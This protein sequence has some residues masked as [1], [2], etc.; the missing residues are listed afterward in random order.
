MS[1]R[2]L[3][4]HLYPRFIAL[5][6]LEDS[7]CFPDPETGKLAIPSAMRCTHI[8]MTANGVY[9]IGLW[10]YSAHRARHG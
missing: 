1:V 4:H 5:H 3:K 10:L 8:D 6:D 9:L 7:A 2:S